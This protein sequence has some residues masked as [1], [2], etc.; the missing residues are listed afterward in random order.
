MQRALILAAPVLLVGCAASIPPLPVYDLAGEQ[1]SHDVRPADRMAERLANDYA[2]RYNSVARDGRIA[3]LPMIAAAMAGAVLTLV[4][5]AG[6]TQAIGLVGIGAGGYQLGR[7]SIAPAAMPMLYAKGH[8]AM[9]CIRA[10]AA[11]FLPN[12]PRPDRPYEETELGQ[13]ESARTVLA[14]NIAAAEK[15]LQVKLTLEPAP[16]AAADLAEAERKADAEKRQSRLAQAAE[17]QSA[18]QSTLVKARELLAESAADQAAGQVAGVVMR[19]AVDAV[20]QRVV[21]KGLEGSVSDYRTLLGLLSPSQPAA[22]AT[23]Q[24]GPPGGTDNAAI[25]GAFGR[26]EATLADAIGEVARTRRPY[27]AALDRVKACPA[28]LG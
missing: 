7:G 19:S 23:G 13:F 5:P 25:A 12:T 18:L 9:G 27:A 20:A 3:N 24:A 16:A 1:H 8:A 2:G 26:S 17:A 4:N 28:T 11:L 21:T 15:N 14:S 22:N 6:A 10:E